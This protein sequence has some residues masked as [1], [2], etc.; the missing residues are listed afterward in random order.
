ME[1]KAIPTIHY[2]GTELNNYG[3][4]FWILNDNSLSKGTLW[5]DQI[6]FN[7]EQTY[8]YQ[9][10]SIHFQVVKGYSVL[11]IAGSCYDHRPASKSVFFTYEELTREE[12]IN[13]LKELPI[14]N[15]IIEQ[16]KFE[17]KF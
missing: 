8:S 6:P 4:Y 14:F 5:F 16:M 9:N 7:P 10:G 15:K 1:L 2:Y 12:F 17:V 11:S 13:K 3:H